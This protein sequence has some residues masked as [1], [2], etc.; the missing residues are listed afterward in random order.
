MIPIVINGIEFQAKEGSTV[1]EALKEANMPFD[2]R[3]VV[4]ITWEEEEIEEIEE[5]Q[6]FEIETTKGLIEI[7]IDDNELLPVWMQIYK[8]FKNQSVGWLARPIVTFGPMDL[9]N[10]KLNALRTSI[11]YKKRDL[12]LS[13]GG[14]DSENAHLCFCK[15]NH[16]GVYGAPETKSKGI[17]GRVIRGEYLLPSLGRTDSIIDIR[18]TKW[19]KE[20]ST[21]LYFEDFL[22]K[23]ITKNMK[24]NSY[25]EVKLSENAPQSVD[26][27]LSIVKNNNNI[28][29]IDF[30]TSMYLQN[31][32]LVG[33][34]VEKENTVFRVKGAITV[35][36]SGHE[37]GSI[38]LYKQ[39]TS[40]TASHNVIGRVT[41]GVDLITHAGLEDRI[42]IRT[43]PD[44]L[45]IIQMTNKKA[46]EYLARRNII[47]IR[48]GYKGDDAIIIEQ[49][50]QYTMM[51]WKQKSVESLGLDPDLLIKIKIDDERSPRSAKH[52][53]TA[54]DMIH[55]PIGRLQILEITENMI[56]FA[57]L[58]RKRT[59]RTV[60]RE[61]SPD[62][63]KPGDIGLTNAIRRLTGLIGIRLDESN[64]YGAT[65]EVLE[66]T[67][68][69]GNVE[70]G[71]DFLKK[72][73]I[74]DIIWIM[75]LK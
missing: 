45:R 43:I 17:F 62:I 69:I 29:S 54:A 50:P 22:E 71:L 37:V 63:Y 30:S 61:Y 41:K 23:K 67:N 31:N 12:F 24:I 15:Q 55:T 58:S 32:D 34:K 16:D 52:F 60:P 14:F 11:K 51:V 26:H 5:T 40:F 49:N 57:P 44:N 3:C 2:K 28:L 19:S 56:L 10:F 1:L 68:Y 75:E 9:R 39:D 70:E 13:F 6:E 35:R 46:E 4:V 66:A 18:P 42:L 72:L 25:I 59:I 65:G 64:E 38:Y 21:I 27:F 8:N 73:D 20:F 7:R 48:N 74:G 36:N 33:I 53:R 47:L